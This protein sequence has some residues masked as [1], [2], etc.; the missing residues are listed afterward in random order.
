MIRRIAL[1]LML[2]LWAVTGGA[3]AEQPTASVV[4][5]RLD[6]STA[7]LSAA[8][9]RELPK[10][11]FTAVDHEKP[12]DY[13]G[14]DVRAVLKAA[15]VESIEGLRGRQ[16]RRVLLVQAAD[17]YA[18]AFAFAELDPTIG[19]KRIYLVDRA[20]GAPLQA[21]AG[22]WRI[23]VPGEGRPTRWVRQVTRLAVVELR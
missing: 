13:S 12:V 16:L 3:R 21:E 22:P 19:N 9:L 2:G 6:G 4:V 14:T 23:V 11:S 5:Q 15:G 10:E 20:A 17:G 7:T 18:A 8:Q 1:F